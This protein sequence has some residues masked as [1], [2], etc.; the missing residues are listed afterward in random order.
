MLALVV[1]G[2]RGESRV[3]V[4]GRLH[5]YRVVNTLYTMIKSRIVMG[6]RRRALYCLIQSYGMLYVHLNR[7]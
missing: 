4:I 7:I 5:S 1:E 6:L 2:N 3:V